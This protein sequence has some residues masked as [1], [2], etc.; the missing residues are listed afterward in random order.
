[1]HVTLSDIEGPKIIL[2][3]HHIIFLENPVNIGRRNGGNKN[4]N[5]KRIE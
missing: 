2:H 1:M 5:N 3:Q 4:V